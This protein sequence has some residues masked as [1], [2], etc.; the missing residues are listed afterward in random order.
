MDHASTDR[1]VL[2]KPTDDI[3]SHTL[4]ALIEGITGVAISDRKDFT[5]SLGH[6]LQRI[7]G[8]RFLTT[9]GAEWNAYREKGR[10]QDDY[11]YTEQHYA[12]LQE[13]LASLDEDMPDERRFETMKRIFLV[14]ATEEYSRREDPLPV[15]FMRTARSLRGGEVLLLHGAH[16]LAAHRAVE[17]DQD[18]EQKNVQMVLRA[19]RERVAKKSGLEFS[20]LVQ[21]YE[22]DL[23]QK[24][25]LRAENSKGRVTLGRYDRLTDYGFAFCEFVAKYE[26]EDT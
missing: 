6:L 17:R 10:I 24:S 3:L 4:Q 1:S 16:Q 9:L 7:R 20:A 15:E 21:R 19:W 12:N 2:A 11:Q 14:S 8:G 25:L 23:V 13:I 26:L 18:A 5:L 22:T